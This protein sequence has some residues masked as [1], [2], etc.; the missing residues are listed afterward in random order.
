MLDR[1]RNRPGHAA[2]QASLHF[3]LWK[4][5]LMI[6]KPL[7]A[8]QTVLDISQVPVGTSIIIFVQT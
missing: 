3:N 5:M 8:V 7:I 6:Q 2:G 4:L 1:N